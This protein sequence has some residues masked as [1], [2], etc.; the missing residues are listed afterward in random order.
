MCH[1]QN[2]AE[3]ENEWNSNTHMAKQ[4]LQWHPV[5]R[6]SD[7]CAVQRETPPHNREVVN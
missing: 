5:Y 1:F 2:V 4:S 3:L 7:I 6:H